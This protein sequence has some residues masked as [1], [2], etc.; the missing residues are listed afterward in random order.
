MLRVNDKPM[1]FRQGMVLAT[2]LME[3]G[4]DSGVP[5]LVTV[6]GQFVEKTKYNQWVLEEDAQILVMPLLSGG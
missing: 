3:A 2:A 5:F 4:V 1:A 6:N